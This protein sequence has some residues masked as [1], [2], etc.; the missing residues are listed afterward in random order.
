MSVQKMAE[1]K[2]TFGKRLK[3]CKMSCYEP[4]MGGAGWAGNSEQT[5]RSRGDPSDD[6]GSLDQ[7]F[8]L[9]LRQCQVQREVS[10]IMG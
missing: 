8:S 2:M 3:D 6:P 10:S 5:R 1:P 7:S 9:A 4:Q